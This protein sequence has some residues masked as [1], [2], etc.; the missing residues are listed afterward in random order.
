[1]LAESNALVS[2]HSTKIRKQNAKR[3]NYIK[4][5]YLGEW[6][7]AH[8][9]LIRP[10]AILR[11]FE[12]HT[13]AIKFQIELEVVWLLIQIVPSVWICL[14]YPIIINDMGRGLMSQNLEVWRR[15][16][17]QAYLGRE[18]AACLCSY[19]WSLLS[20]KSLPLTH[21]ISSSTRRKR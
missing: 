3:R 10:H 16:G 21:P 11:L 2:K 9:W 15:R 18:K 12:T 13:R 14:S 19:C 1:M 8:D 6:S 7:T 5:N 20:Q 17:S 4:C